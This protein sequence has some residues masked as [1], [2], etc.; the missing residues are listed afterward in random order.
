M[1]K[2]EFL[3]ALSDMWKEFDS[4]V[5]RYKV[6][7]ILLILVLCFFFLWYY[8]FT[9]LLIYCTKLHLGPCLVVKCR[10]VVLMYSSCWCLNFN[11]LDVL[12]VLT[13]GLWYQEQQYYHIGNISTSMGSISFWV[14]RN[15]GIIFV[16]HISIALM[17]ETLVVAM[18]MAR[19]QTNFKQMVWMFRFVKQNLAGFN[20]NWYIFF[21][22]G[23]FLPDL[24]RGPVYQAQQ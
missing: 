3:K 11:I 17:F 21:D 12:L 6:C 23:H 2:T 8:R 10:Q 18:L 20:E 5:L 14:P 13:S 16:L 4:R 9:I 19:H 15:S 24:D 7:A 1:Q 22:Y